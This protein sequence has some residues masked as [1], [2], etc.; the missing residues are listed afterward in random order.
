MQINKEQKD[1]DEKIFKEQLE[2]KNL[3]Y[4]ERRNLIINI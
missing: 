1:K 3:S 2:N 4:M